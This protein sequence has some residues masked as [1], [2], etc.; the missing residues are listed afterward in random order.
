MASSSDAPS[1]YTSL[2][3]ESISNPPTLALKSTNVTIPPALGTILVEIL[4]A[5]VQS[6]HSYHLAGLIHYLTFPVPFTPGNV[7]VGRVLSPTPADGAF[8]KPGDLVLVDSFIRAR[9]APRDHQIMLGL[10][11]GRSPGEKKMFAEAYRHS[12]TWSEVSQLPLE[13]VFK[14]DET[15]IKNLG[16]ET[17]DLSYIYR[18][19]VAMGGARAAELKAGKT[20]AIGPAAGS[21]SGA[22]VETASALGCKVIALTR[23]G[24][25]EGII[26]KMA[27][28]HPQIHVAVMTG[29]KEADVATIRS[30][31]T[32]GSSGLD[33]FI[34][35]SP[36]VTTVP[37]HVNPAI[38]C[39]RPGGRIVFMGALQKLEIPVHT[40]MFKNITLKGQ[41][42]YERKDVEL[43]LRMVELGLLKLGKA[44]GHE[45]VGEFG[46]EEW[47]K[48][49]EEAKES[50]LWGKQMLF[51]PKK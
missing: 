40:F 6:T 33:A 21:F 49:L 44:A 36:P 3:L 29:E 38:D 31:L 23:P 12:G 13:N 25:S 35:Y 27:E 18:L 47:E 24:K 41:Y 51:T 4:H 7:G 46:F 11:E 20:I 37:D 16:L 43:T 26:K 15:A 48:A 42:M 39:V 9:D 17:K 8:L 10:H 2:V 50:G 14:I 1:T 32:E 19:F 34:E 30:L 5:P 28:F 22:M 45:T